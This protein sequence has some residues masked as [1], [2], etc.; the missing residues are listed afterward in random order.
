MIV[1]LRKIQK[2][3]FFKGLPNAFYLSNGFITAVTDDRTG[4]LIT[5]LT[6]DDEERLEKALNYP[7]G[8]LAYNSPFWDTFGVKLQEG[9]ATLNDELP[10]DELKLKMLR[11]QKKV[12]NGTA[13]L[14]TKS[15]AQYVLLNDEVEAVQDNSK[16][17]T[18]REA[19][20]LFEEKFAKSVDDMKRVLLLYGKKAK[21]TSQDSIEAA[22]TMEIEKDPQR[23]LDTVNGPNFKEKVFLSELLQ[24]GIL[25]KKGDLIFYGDGVWANS[26]EHFVEQ[27]KLKKHSEQYLLWKEQLQSK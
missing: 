13:E 27:I 22:L 2:E 12:A 4:Y 18:K 17:K 1:K 8:H 9:Q 24:A 19:Y 23:F 6:K 11:V 16:F 7:K 3:S 15:N 25:R 14:K 21:T 5:G 10:E 26:P 20:K